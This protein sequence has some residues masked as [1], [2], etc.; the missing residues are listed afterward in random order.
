MPSTHTFSHP[1]IQ[2][3]DLVPTLACGVLLQEWLPLD[4][5]LKSSAPRG[6]YGDMIRIGVEAAEEALAGGP[7]VSSGMQVK[8]LPSGK[9]RKTGIDLAALRTLAPPLFQLYCVL[10]NRPACFISY[11]LPGSYDCHHKLKEGP[12][13]CVMRAHVMHAHVCFRA[14]D[15][16][17]YCIVTSGELIVESMYYAAKL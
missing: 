13:H 12:S 7:G 6:L 10:A 3:E 4:D 1:L 8:R 9:D 17:H 5:F 11:R 16:L 2:T 14:R 15:A